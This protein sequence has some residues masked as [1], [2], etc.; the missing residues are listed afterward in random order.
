MHHL[1]KG[2]DNYIGNYGNILLLFFFN[3][4]FSEKKLQVLET[5]I[6]KIKNGIAPE[7]MKDIFEL[8]NPSYNLRSSCN[9]FRRENTKTVYYGLQSLRYVGPKIRELVANN[10]K[11]FNSLSKFGKLIKS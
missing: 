10:I 1:G 11:Y 7:I 4:E 2:L 3:S 5:E 8:Q 6:Y 9:Q